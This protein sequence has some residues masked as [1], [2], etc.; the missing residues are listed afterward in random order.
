M[1]EKSLPNQ[2]NLEQYK[3]QAKDLLH[4]HAQGAPEAMDRIQ[5]YHPRFHDKPHDAV[6]RATFKLAD[7]QFIITREHGF[8]SWP[9]FAKHIRAIRMNREVASLDD[10]V[11]AFIEAACSPRD[12]HRLGALEAAEAI[13]ARYPQVAAHSIHT[14]SIVADEST[15]RAFHARDPSNATA[16]GGL[17][18]WDAL[19]HLCF[20]RYLR[21]DRTRSDAFVRTAQALLDAGAS[22]NTG[23]IEMIDQPNPRPLLEAVGSTALPPLR[24]MPRSHVYYSK[25]APTLTMR[26][27]HTT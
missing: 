4:A 27:P 23:W 11:S 17:L 13:L 26:R 24:S 18:G 5:R 7:A 19:T 1:P 16:K 25:E 8:E 6:Q 9:Q 12:G 22:A 20:S 15:V 14:A 2:P 3:K 10:P 21:L